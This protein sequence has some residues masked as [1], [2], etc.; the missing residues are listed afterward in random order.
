MTGVRRPTSKGSEGPAITTRMID[1]SQA[2]RFA[3]FG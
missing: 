1:A 2:T 3:T